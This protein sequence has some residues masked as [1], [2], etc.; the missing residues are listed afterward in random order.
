M[1]PSFTQK[2]RS[3]WRSTSEPSRTVNS[4]AKS[5]SYPAFQGEFAQTSATTTA[6]NSSE[7]LAVDV[8]RNSCNGCTTRLG[9]SR[10][11]R[12]HGGRTSSK[13][14]RDERSAWIGRDR[15]GH[16][17]SSRRPVFP[18]HLLR[19]QPIVPVTELTR[20]CRWRGPPPPVG[21]ARFGRW[22][23]CSHPFPEEAPPDR[24]RPRGRSRSPWWRSSR[25]PAATPVL[26]PT[27]WATTPPRH[28]SSR[29]R[30]A[31]RRPSRH[32]RSRTIRPP[33]LPRRR[34]RPPSRSS[35]TSSTPRPS[36]TRATGWTGST[37]TC[38][39]SS[40]TTPAMPPRAQLDVLTAGTGGRRGLRVD[41][42]EAEHA[43]GPRAPRSLARAARRRGERT[44]R[45]PRHGRRRPGGARQQGPVR[46]RED[47]RRVARGLVLGAAQR[48]GA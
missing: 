2:C 9:T 21:S 26:S 31:S 38:S 7:A 25:C 47:R 17:D 18:A 43:Q 3:F 16:D 15:F 39:S 45:R 14:S 28:P 41:H 42:A 34:P 27:S 33:S 37:T 24:R 4:V 23:A 44:L 30:R 11:D 10:S 12:D 6:R 5:D 36:S 19:R 20:R 48:R 1:S 35:S 8:C 32:R 22:S 40:P 46:P 29:S 13:T